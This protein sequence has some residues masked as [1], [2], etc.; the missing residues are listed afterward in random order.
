MGQLLQALH[1]LQVN[2]VAIIGDVRS[3]VGSM[4]MATGDIASGNQDLSNRTEA[5]ASSL[6]Q[7]ASRPSQSGND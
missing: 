7:T 2:L 4:Q 1:Q 6:E 5:Q 3:N